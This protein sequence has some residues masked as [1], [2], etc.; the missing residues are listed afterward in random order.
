MA[1]WPLRFAPSPPPAPVAEPDWD[2]LKAWAR[3][4]LLHEIPPD[5][6]AAWQ[7]WWLPKQQALRAKG[8][9]S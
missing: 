6:E 4:P 1:H 8:K 9:E 7:S 3:I 2:G 5:V